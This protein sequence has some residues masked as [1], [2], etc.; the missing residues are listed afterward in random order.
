M[1]EK[2]IAWTPTIFA[3]TYLYET[4]KKNIEEGNAGN[5]DSYCKS[6]KSS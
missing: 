4:C 6:C 2:G 3:Y 5:P 1:K